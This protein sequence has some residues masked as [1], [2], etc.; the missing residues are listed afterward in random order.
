MAEPVV[1]VKDSFVA[2]TGKLH[3]GSARMRAAFLDERQE[4]TLERDG[5]VV[6]DFLSPAELQSVREGIRKLGFGV[7]GDGTFAV[8]RS[9][10]RISV[11]Q[12]DA[13]QRNEIFE[14][15]SPVFRRAA[16][17]FLRNYSLLRIGIFDKLPGGA[18][19]T[20]HQHSSLVDESQYRSLATWVPLVDM[21]VERGTMSV[22]KGSHEFSRHIRSYNDFNRAFRG[23]SKRLLERYGTALLLEAG[24]AIIFDD[25]LVHWSPRNRSSTVRTAI[26]LE[27][28][29][30]EAE[31]TVYFRRDD[32]ELLKYRLDRTMY[33]RTPLNED[34]PENLEQIGTVRQPLVTFSDEQFRSLVR[35]M[36]PV[37]AESIERL[38]PRVLDGLRR[39][40]RA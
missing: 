37:A 10:L 36:N 9:R 29:P 27:L 17:R 1:I 19:I 26:Q 23:V 4:E 5:G 18:E 40:L 35:D 20:V 16:A 12:G 13:A 31:L 3:Y 38:L 39:R 6:V 34:R 28:I 30:E 22:I 11:T 14:E 2:A 32:Q 33:R 25:R 8:P 15:L 21:T 24:Q 7:E